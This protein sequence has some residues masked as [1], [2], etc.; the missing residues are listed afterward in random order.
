MQYAIEKSFIIAVEIFERISASS[1][2]A[3]EFL[4]VE[5]SITISIS[6]F[7]HFLELVIG[8]LLS[9][10][11]CDS[12]Q[13]FEGDFVEVVLIEKFEN[14]QNFI[15]GVSRSLNNSIIY[16]AGGHHSRKFIEVQSL[17]DLFSKF[18]VDITNVLL[19][20]LHSESLHNGL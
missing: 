16:H 9:Y 7:K 5:H 12:L 19:F 3:V 8:N 2:D 1:H 17:L 11:I 14:L 13:I 20:D 10:L 15:F 18:S 4:E 6:L